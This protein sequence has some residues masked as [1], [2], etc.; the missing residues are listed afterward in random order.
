[1]FA[2]SG[3]LRTGQI[4]DFLGYIANVPGVTQGS[5]AAAG[6]TVSP[7]LD[8]TSKECFTTKLSFRGLSLAEPKWDFQVDVWTSDV[9]A[10]AG[11]AAG[12]APDVRHQPAGT[13]LR[14]C[15]FQ[16]LYTMY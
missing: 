5:A 15:R 14:E 16:G 11:G 4:A 1:M 3:K 13:M 9:M 7:S 10:G 6:A 8:S 12:P 2:V